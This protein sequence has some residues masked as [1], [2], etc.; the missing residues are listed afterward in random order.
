VNFLAYS[1][2][3]SPFLILTSGLAQ[4]QDLAPLGATLLLLFDRAFGDETMAHLAE[5]SGR[6]VVVVQRGLW[7]MVGVAEP[8]D[9]CIMKAIFSAQW[10]H[11]S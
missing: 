2:G 9:I 3:A 11:Y 10:N 4:A 6:P 7:V 8:I 5:V 1:T